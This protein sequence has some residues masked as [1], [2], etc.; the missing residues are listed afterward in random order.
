MND[1]NN[2][3]P[4][5]P[6]PGACDSQTW[7]T[8]VLVVIAFAALIAALWAPI[9]VRGTAMIEEWS[10]YVAFDNGVRAIAPEILKGQS[11]RP[12]L[13]VSYALAHWLTPDSFVGLNV[14]HLALLFFKGVLFYAV[15]ARLLPT[16][17]HAAFLI[18]ALMMIFPA[19]TGIF[20][21]RYTPYHMAVD[22]FL[23]ALVALLSNWDRPKVWKLPVM[24]LGLIVCLGS[25][26]VAFPLV[27]FT[28]VLLW[29][30]EKKLNAR[31]L[32]FAALWYAAPAIMAVW[33]VAV[34]SRAGTYQAGQLAGESSSGVSRLWA[35]WSRVRHAY[36]RHFFEGW[37]EAIT[38]PVPAAHLWISIAVILGSAIVAFALAARHRAE[39]APRSRARQGGLLLITGLLALGLGYLAFVPSA[40]HALTHERVFLFS[41]LG[42]AAAIGGL[43]LLLCQTI[44]RCARALYVVGMSGLVGIAMV[45]ALAQQKA[46]EVATH[47]EQRLLSGI[48]ARVPAIPQDHALLLF[49]DYASRYEPSQPMFAMNATRGHFEDAVRYIYHDPSL[50]VHVLRQAGPGVPD[51]ERCEPGPNRVDVFSGDARIA[52]YSYEKIYALRYELDGEVTLLD[53]FPAG[54]ASETVSASKT[55]VPLASPLPPRALTVLNP[56]LRAMPVEEK[57]P[58]NSVHFEFDESRGGYGFGPPER[59]PSH[60]VMWMISPTALIEFWLEGTSD[61]TIDVGVLTGI[62]TDI[63]ES[64]HLRVNGEP[65]P[66]KM[67]PNPAGTILR[68][69]IPQ[70]AVAANPKRT[71]L[72]FQTDRVVSPK[73]LGASDDP[74][75]FGVLFDWIKVSPKLR[76]KSLRVDFDRLVSGDGWGPPEGSPALSVIW[77]VTPTSFIDCWLDPSRDYKVEFCVLRGLTADIL[78]SLAMSVN[79]QSIPLQ[80]S[81]AEQGS[82]IFRGTIPR[83]AVSAD[84]KNTKLTFSINR[85]ASPES[86]G[87]NSDPRVLGVL[88][89]WLAIDPED[90]G[91]TPR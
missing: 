33:T 14:V 46:M 4:P 37:S 90:G 55:P 45:G 82:T 12:F 39:R 62:T 69:M 24:W 61:Y 89:D 58:A 65:I 36:L 75:L 44:P 50:K 13:L 18:A 83:S 34:I 63:L 2:A 79:G 16:A 78:D 64:L 76:M 91:N 3:S 60:T 8:S 57:R 70:T 23:L 52:S 67:L 85:V 28:P 53:D 21:V 40:A 87:M 11:N 43:W 56:S 26:E 73:S 29:W 54:Y 71:R 74:R 72:N 17:R 19:D 32:R 6:P 48:V 51:A 42:G 84:P 77:S 15:L 22:S 47:G 30:Q 49:Y 7:R 41:S 86:L 25:Y 27:F 59:T 68:G 10:F 80:R 31:L 9:G 5:T 1:P 88:F 20:N 66:L 35:Y 38:P 81:P